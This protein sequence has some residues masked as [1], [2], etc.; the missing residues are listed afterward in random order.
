MAAKNEKNKRMEGK[1]KK[2]KGE[3][4]K[5]CPRVFFQFDPKSMILALT[6]WQQADLILVPA[7]NPP[8]FYC[9]CP[10]PHSPSSSFPIHSLA[11]VFAVGVV[12]GPLLSIFIPP[13]STARHPSSE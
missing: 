4:Q 1:L 11:R 6:N 8:P 9:H 2:E 10:S 3:W 5:C 7:D 12:F 13:T